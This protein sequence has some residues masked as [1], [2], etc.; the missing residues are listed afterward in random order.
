ML[1]LTYESDR[2]AALMGVAAKRQEQSKDDYVFGLWKSQ[3][4]AGLSWQAAHLRPYAS[5]NQCNA[6]S[7]SWPASQG[8]GVKFTSDDVFGCDMEAEVVDVDFEPL[9]NANPEPGSEY[10][11]LLRGYM[12]RFKLDVRRRV[13]PPKVVN[14]NEQ[15]ELATFSGRG[16]KV[17]FDSPYE[18]PTRV[19]SLSELQP[20]YYFKLGVEKAV[21]E[22]GGVLHDEVYLVLNQ[23]GTYPAPKF[24]RVGLMRRPLPEYPLFKRRIRFRV[25]IE[26]V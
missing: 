6:P 14:R 15:A 12:E 16:A 1:N 21:G 10:S 9:Q 19:Q 25:Q 17:V 2:L 5:N 13:S 8:V 23:V 20:F 18:I 26:I 7:W 22:D 3:L 11:L 24:K 4:L